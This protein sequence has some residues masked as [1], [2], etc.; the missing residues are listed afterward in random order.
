MFFY[1]RLDLPSGL[2]SSGFPTKML[3]AFLFFPMRA[4]YMLCSYYSPW[5]HS[6]LYL[7]EITGYEPPHCAVFSNPLLLHPSV[8]QIVRLRTKTTEFVCLWSKYS[9]QLPVLETYRHEAHHSLPSNA[10]VRK[11]ASI[12]PL[13]H[14]S[15]RRRGIAYGVS[16]FRKLEFKV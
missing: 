2:F 10:E 11:D 5:R 15:S 9:P 7:A 8:V 3:Y 14:A 16:G 13:P 12:P 6:K 1:L 4:Y